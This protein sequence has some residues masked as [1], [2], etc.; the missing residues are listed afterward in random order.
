MDDFYIFILGFPD[1]LKS[2]CC[3]FA[4]SWPWL[5]LLSIKEVSLGLKNLSTKFW[6]GPGEKGQQLFPLQARMQLH[7]CPNSYL[8]KTV[9]SAM[10]AAVKLNLSHKSQLPAMCVKIS[11]TWYSTFGL[12]PCFPG[13]CNGDLQFCNSWAFA[14]DRY[15]KGLLDKH[16]KVI[17]GL[18]EAFTILGNWN[19]ERREARR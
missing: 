13:T 5:C 1:F 18:P 7:Q 15:L 12:F 11:L 17:M 14:W 6:A 9:C 8:C 10:R 3:A 16:E 2:T 4:S 19:L